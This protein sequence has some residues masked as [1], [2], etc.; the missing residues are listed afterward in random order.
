MGRPTPSPRSRQ[1]IAAFIII[2]LGWLS[3][4]YGHRYNFTFGQYLPLKVLAI[5]LIACGVLV[6]VMA[7]KEIHNTHYIEHL[8]TSGIYSRTRNPVYLA[9]GLIIAGIAFLS[10]SF[11]S[12]IWVLIS[13]LIIFWITKREEPDLE[14]AFG[15]SYLKY[16]KGVPAFFPRFWRHK[17]I[18]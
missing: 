13:I 18:N 5:L 8:V 17:E 2:L 14:K 10:R 4:S 1:V 11:L 7:F 12:F 3:I 16:K 9:F 15:D 6:R